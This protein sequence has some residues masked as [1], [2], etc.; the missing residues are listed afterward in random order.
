VNKQTQHTTPH[1]AR[2]RFGQHFLNDE[3]VI[4]R[5]I[6][7]IAPQVG[8][9]IVEIGP[10]LG[11]LT[12]PLLEETKQLSVI[13]LDRDVIPPLNARCVHIGKLNVHCADVLNFNFKSVA[14]NNTPLRLVGNL[15][16]NISTPLLFHILDQIHLIQD[17]VFM[18]Q[19]E[20]ADRLVATPGTRDYGRLSVMMQYHCAVSHLFDVA[21]EAFTP[22]PKVYSSIVHFKPHTPL[23]VTA[24]D[25]VFFAKLVK[26]AFSQ[27]R[28]TL[29]NTLKNIA[30]EDHFAR[31]NINSTSRA[32]SLSVA[33]FVTLSN[34]VGTSK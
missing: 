22:P 4:D 6:R 27:R 8:E 20:V 21:P 3:Q 28:K 5:I 12:A 13:E 32:E 17:M 29:R 25:D 15:P 11:A 31:A 26:Q 30:N 14:L 2:K 7:A 18:F 1:R 33:E 16:Y 10:G 24:Q 19:K 9:Q 23:P 34:S